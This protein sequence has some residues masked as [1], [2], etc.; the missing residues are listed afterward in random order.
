MGS[1]LGPSGYTTSGVPGI[2]TG[3]DGSLP[4][5]VS[6]TQD[7][8]TA[9]YQGQVQDSTGWNG[10]SSSFFGGILG[11]FS[12]AVGLVTNAVDDLLANL[13]NAITGLSG[14]LI[15]LSS[16]ATAL[17]GGVTTAQSTATAAQSSATAAMAVATGKP[18]LTQIPIGSTLWA[19]LGIGEDAT[20]LRTSLSFG[21]ASSSSSG[22]SST[23]SAH[24]HPLGAIP[25][26]QPAG[27]GSN[28]IEI[29]YIRASRDRTYTTAGFITG[30]SATFAGITG[31]YLGVFFVNPTTGALTLLNT[32]SAATNIASAITTTNT[33]Q[34]FSLGYTI[35]ASQGDTFAVALL[36][37]TSILQT[38]ASLMDTT[39]TALG[40][41]SSAVV[42]QANYCYASPYTAMP[43]SIAAAA[44]NYGASTKLPFYFLS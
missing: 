36:Q 26:Y 12:N 37:V 30:G 34:S 11:G 31:A 40:A 15:D 10:A 7:N 2:V 33:Q 27:N 14:G 43:S 38:C 19:S 32:T 17:E 8:V 42:P 24:T 9:T 4:S 6:N 21:S 16:W 23:A 39:L 18:S 29:G 41:S 44:L 13:C 1:P 25:Q 5:M 3:N 35:S 22:G 20:F 28:T